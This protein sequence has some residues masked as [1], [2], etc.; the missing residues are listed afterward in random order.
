MLVLE[1]DRGDVVEVI[2]NGVVVAEVSPT[3]GRNHKIGFR[4]SASFVRKGAK[5]Q[6]PRVD[7]KPAQ[8]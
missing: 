4:G 3:Q 7:A 1:L 2:V 8:P 5:N 6:E